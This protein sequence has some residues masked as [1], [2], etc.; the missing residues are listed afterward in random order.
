MMNIIRTTATILICLVYTFSFGQ[1]LQVGQTIEGEN[2][3]DLAGE[4]LAMNA[5]GTRIVSLERGY[6]GVEENSGRIKVFEFNGSIW[7][8]LG[9]DIEGEGLNFYFGGFYP[10]SM[11]AAGTRFCIGAPFIDGIDGI[12]GFE[13]GIVRAYEFDGNNWIQIGQTIT[14][15]ANGDWSGR[16]LK[17]SDDGNRVVIGGHNNDENGTNSGHVRVFEYNGATWDQLGQDIDGDASGDW[18][19]FAISIDK[20]GSRIVIGAHQ[21][22]YNSNSN[23]QVGQVKIYQFNGETWE[24]LG[25]DLYGLGDNSRFG[26]SVDISNDGNIIAIG[27]WSIDGTYRGEVRVF[28]YSQGEWILLGQPIIGIEDFSDSGAGVSLRDDGLCIAVTG[29]LYMDG[30]GYVAIYHYNGWSWIQQGQTIQGNEIL[31]RFGHSVSIS[32]DGSIVA[33]S[34]PGSDSAN[35]ENTGSVKVFSSGFVGVKESTLLDNFTV[36]PNPTSG[37]IV[38]EFD[39]A[40]NLDVR[41]LSTTGQILNRQKITNSNKFD[42][43]IAGPS[44]IYFIEMIDE[45][46]RSAVFEVVKE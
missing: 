9:Q 10:L 24:Q 28:K 19:G 26:T 20:D 6:D 38:I 39:I 45:E 40:Q 16:S 34:A 21:N 44:G 7:E 22:D 1:W 37:P 43:E 8:Q 33:V 15:E 12:L 14:G 29:P 11:N 2:E 30:T 31:D 17:L 36:Y 5:D 35:G 27:S 23:A 13:S 42:L 46:Q 32:S 25:E 41:L 18:S 3:F 4:A